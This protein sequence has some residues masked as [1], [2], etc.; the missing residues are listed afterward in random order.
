MEQKDALYVVFW[1]AALAFAL[2]FFGFREI[3]PFLFSVALVGA[4]F[5]ER[6]ESLPYAV[7]S[8]FIALVLFI[9]IMLSMFF[10]APD[11]IA[12]LLFLLFPFVLME[13]R[14][15]FSK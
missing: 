14:K 7:G 5:A 11:L 4:V 9:Y 12:V 8:A 2:Y 10:L 13:V 6:M 15:K 3:A 1:S